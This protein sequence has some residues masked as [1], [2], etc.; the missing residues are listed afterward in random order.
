[1]ILLVAT[2]IAIGFLLWPRAAAE[3]SEGFVDCLLSK[4]VQMY[5]SDNCSVCADQKRVFGNDFEKIS[6]INCDFNKEECTNKGVTVYPVWAK[7]NSVLVGLQS[8]ET[9]SDFSGCRL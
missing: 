2:L 7:G 8:L 3:S 9:L 5:G 1:M 6:Y 4:S